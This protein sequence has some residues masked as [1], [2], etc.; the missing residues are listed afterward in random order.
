MAT[1]VGSL[2]GDG[3]ARDCDRQRRQREQKREAPPHFLVENSV[4]SYGERATAWRVRPKNER[5]RYRRP[6]A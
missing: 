5:E 3:G 4:W 1:S 2:T 6:L